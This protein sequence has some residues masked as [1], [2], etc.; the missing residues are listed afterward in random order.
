MPASKLLQLMRMRRTYLAMVVDEYGSTVGLIG[1]EDI[2]EELVGAIQNEHT[3][4]K[5]EIQP[6]PTALT[7]LP[8]RSSSTTSKNCCTSPSKTTSIPIPSAATS[9]TP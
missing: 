4:E 9:L 1:L 2:L 3:T 5:E 8:G 6:F 7:N